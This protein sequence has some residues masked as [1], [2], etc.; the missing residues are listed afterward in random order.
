V[1]SSKERHDS[2][3]LSELVMNKRVL[4]PPKHLKD[5]EMEDAAPKINKK[6]AARTRARSKLSAVESQEISIADTSAR[7]AKR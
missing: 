3:C 4:Q 7:K 6:T 1:G 5:Y 2:V